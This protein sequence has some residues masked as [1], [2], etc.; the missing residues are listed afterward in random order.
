MTWG[1]PARRAVREVRRLLARER[2]ALL[3]GRYEV[4]AAC[5][6][7]RETLIAGMTDL[8][9][10]ALTGLREEALAL[11]RELAHNRDL[12]AAARDGLRAARARPASDPGAGFAIY[13]AEGAVHQQQAPGGRTLGK[14]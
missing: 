6:A 4:V 1:D 2:G 14:S 7:R 8:P 5:V 3:S 9:R 12:F 13:T 10:D 11:D